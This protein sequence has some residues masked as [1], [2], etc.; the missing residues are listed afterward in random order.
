MRF[1]HKNRLFNLYLSCIIFLFCEQLIHAAPQK[2]S[3]VRTITRKNILYRT[4]R[5]TRIH[6]IPCHII[7]HKKTV[8]VAP[9]TKVLSKTFVR[10]PILHKPLKIP[11]KRAPAHTT[12][13]YN[14]VQLQKLSAPKTA[15]NISTSK[16]RRHNITQ[17][18]QPHSLG[19]CGLT[20]WSGSNCYMNATLQCL[21]H[22]QS[23]FNHLNQTQSHPNTL[24]SDASTLFTTMA[25]TNETTINPQ[26][27]ARKATQSYFKET[28]NKHYQQDA[29]EFLSQF[30]DHVA[31]NSADNISLLGIQ[32]NICCD[33]CHN[34]STNLSQENILPLQLPS[35]QQQ[36]LSVQ[37]CINSFFAPEKL[38]DQN[39]YYCSFCGHETNAHKQLTLIH[40]PQMLVLQLKRFAFDNITKKSTK[41]N[42]PV[43]LTTSLTVPYN[44][45]AQQYILKGIVLHSGSLYSGHYT[46][47]VQGENNQIMLCNDSNV[48]DGRSLW[49]NLIKAG[50]CAYGTPYLLFYEKDT[51]N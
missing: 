8:K 29:E 35:H 44:N 38:D 23:F 7:Q 37:H 42:I 22:C 46:A 48:S 3:L 47:L 2:K 50:T 25:N 10:Q 27:F 45:T 41:N 51:K 21:A 15:H 32:S 30:L 43:C 14:Y 9:K 16:Q 4:L 34:K 13:H 5:R 40:T 33:S 20:N 6:R 24:H 12:H 39:L 36:M 18:L 28:G 17:T 26:Y 31:H 49:L 11:V 1:S 19:A